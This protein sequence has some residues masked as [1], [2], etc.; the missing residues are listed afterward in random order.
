MFEDFVCTPYPRINISLR[1]KKISVES[2]YTEDNPRN[3]ILTKHYKIDNPRKLASTNLN[4]ST[5]TA[6]LKTLPSDATCKVQ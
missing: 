5:E 1:T 4:N 3:P 2:L 6:L